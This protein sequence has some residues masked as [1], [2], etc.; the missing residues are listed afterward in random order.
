MSTPQEILKQYWGYDN[1]KLQ[2]KEI[3]ESILAKKDTLG[4][5][6]TGGGKSICYQVPALIKGGLCIV[7]T[8]LIALMKDQALG[9]ARR[10]IPTLAIHSGMSS[11][12][13]EETYNK[14]DTGQ[15]S[16]IFISPERLATEIFQKRSEF[17]EVNLIVVDEAHCVSEWG[18]DFRPPY[19]LIGT[20]RDLYK[21]IPILALTASATQVVKEDICTQLK[22]SNNNIISATIFRENLSLS[23]RIVESKEEKLLLTLQTISGS[24][25]VY[26]RN[27]ATT[28][29]IQILLEGNGITAEAYNGGIDMIKRNTVQDQWIKNEVSVIVC[30]NAFGMGID[31]ADVRIVIHFDVPESI[32][33]YYQEVGRAGR[34]G[35]RAYGLLLFR[36]NEL[37]DA[38]EKTAAKYPEN[39]KLIQYYKQVGDYLRISFDEGAEELHDF[40]INEFCVAH[41]LNPFETYNALKLLELQG[42]LSLNEGLH[43]PA[44]LKITAD[45]QDIEYLEIHHPILAEVIKAA[46]RLYGGIVYNH[47]VIQEHKIAQLAEVDNQ[48]VKPSLYQLQSMGYLNYIGHKEKPQLC[49]LEDRLRDYDMYLDAPLLDMLRTRFLYRLEAMYNFVKNETDCRMKIMTTYFNEIEQTDCLKCDNCVAVNKN[50]QPTLQNFVLLQEKI[51]NLLLEKAKTIKE[52]YQHLHQFKKQEIELVLTELLKNNLIKIN[53]KGYLEKNDKN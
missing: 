35:F 14:A 13:V 26:C 52:I 49:L 10:K 1:F 44:R 8:P 6:P 36:T 33:A 17:W 21:D 12:E 24:A 38:V 18:F 15:F 30:T 25:I 23:S 46:L 50:K 53:D 19:L 3:I 16:F 22:F 5:L 31:K 27:R 11:Y 32:E 34:D 39:K 37:K 42:F 4:I 29:R 40:D 47:I 41:S 48:I 9:L 45:R 51:E 28:H 7:I 20:Y 2:Q 43:F